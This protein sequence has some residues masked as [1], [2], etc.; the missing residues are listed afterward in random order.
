MRLLV[1]CCSKFEHSFF[2]YPTVEC[3]NCKKKGSY[4]FKVDVNIVRHSDISFKILTLVLPNLIRIR[5]NCVPTLL[6]MHLQVMMPIILQNTLNLPSLL[7]IL[8]IYSDNFFLFVTIILLP[9][10]HHTRLF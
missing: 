3:H 4:C 8:N 1:L 6:S 9:L 5:I 2:N 10:F 7:L